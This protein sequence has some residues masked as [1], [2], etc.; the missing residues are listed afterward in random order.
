MRRLQKQRRRAT[1]DQHRDRA[2]DKDKAKDKDRASAMR[3]VERSPT[4][5]SVAAIPKVARSMKA[6]GAR[7]HETSG[8]PTGR[9]SPHVVSSIVHALVSNRLLFFVRPDFSRLHS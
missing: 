7:P 3:A 1:P 2:R 9:H 5:V 6:I 4:S 8:P